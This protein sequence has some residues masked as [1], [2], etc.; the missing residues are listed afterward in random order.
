MK[1][2]AVEDNP[3]DVEI[4]RE[5]LD[6]QGSAFELQNVK[7]LAAAWGV[8]SKGETEFILIDLGLPD[9]QGI[10]T[11]RE[12]RARYPSHPIVVLTGFDDEETGMLALHEGAQDYLVKGQITG[13]SLVRSIRYAYERNR[14][15]QELVRKNIALDAANEELT[16]TDRELR[17]KNKKLIAAYEDLTAIHEELR[18]VNDE[19]IS[20]NFQLTALNEKLTAAQGEL[21]QYLEELTKSEQDLK[22][23][24]ANLKE[25]LAEK[26]ILLSEIHHRVKNNLA[27]FISL[28]SLEG[29]SEDTP[30]GRMLRQDLQNRARSMALIH[31]TLYRTNTFDKVNM[32]MYLTTLIDQIAQT[33][34]SK[35]SVMT[36]VDV[37]GIMLD[38]PRA[39]PAGLIINELVTNSFKYAFPESFDSLAVRHASPTISLALTRNEGAYTLIVRDN[40][41]G[42]PPE[43][44]LSK[45]KT[46]GLKLV[47]FLAKHQMHAKVEVNTANGTEFVFRLRK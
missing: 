15:E 31:E 33:F 24:E 38:I 10:A 44:D 46:L 5:L 6:P 14:I 11:L 34:K 19:L 12:V 47:N 37:K 26:E 17:Q 4:L 32:E 1:I 18:Q 43:I 40:G 41:V 39:T 30:A 28:L 23:S 9:S 42:L 36:S 13:L 16:A 21:R 27:A 3:A 35:K 8:L 29:S 7:T 22:R 20:Y 25:A 2:L 45:T